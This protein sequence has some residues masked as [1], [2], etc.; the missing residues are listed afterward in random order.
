MPMGVA[1]WVLLLPGAALSLAVALRKGRLRLRECD[2]LTI[3][4]VV[5]VIGLVLALLPGLLRNTEG[6]LGLGIYDALYY[7]QADAWLQDH[8]IREAAQPDASRYD[9]TKAYGAGS[10]ELPASRCFGSRRRW[11]TFFRTSPDRTIYALLSVLLTLLPLTIWVSARA[12]GVGLVAAALGAAFGLSPALLMLVPDSALGNLAGLVLAPPALFF[13]IR[14]LSSGQRADIAPAAIL[15]GGLF[16]V[17]PE[18]VPPLLAAS[19]IGLFVH[20]VTCLRESRTRARLRTLATRLVL[21]AAATILI[22]PLPVYRAFRYLIAIGA[23]VQGQPDR[24]LTF[25]N[26]WAWA[27]GVLHLYQLPRFE[28]LSPLRTA[29][30]VALPVALALLLGLGVARSGLRRGAFVAVP[31]GTAILLGFVAYYRYQGGHCEYCL[32][33][34][35]TFLLPFVAIGLA[36]GVQRAWGIP[37]RLGLGVPLRRAAM[38]IAACGIAALIW[39]DRKLEQAS[40]YTPAVISPELRQLAKDSSL[41]IGS[42]L[43][44]EDSDTSAVSVWTTPATYYLAQGIDDVRLSFVSEGLAAAYLGIPAGT[45][46]AYYSANYQYV[47]TPFGGVKSNRTV[48][49]RR[50]P[51]ALLRR[52]LIDVTPVNLGW[53]FDPNSRVSAIPWVSKPFQLWLSNLQHERSVALTIALD[54]PFHDASTLV[55]SERG[56]PLSALMSSDGSRL[57]VDVDARK[58]LTIVDAAP[59]LATAA[60]VPPRATE[61]DPFPSPPKVLGLAE[62]QAVPGRCIGLQPRLVSQLAYGHG[63]QSAE[64]DPNGVKFRWM[65][66]VAHLVV[67][68]PA[69]PSGGT[70]AGEATVTRRRRGAATV[71]VAYGECCRSRS[72]GCYPLT[73]SATETAAL[74]AHPVITPS[75]VDNHD[76]QLLGRPL[77]PLQAFNCTKEEFPAVAVQDDDS[78]T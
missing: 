52:A 44:V 11:R 70:A 51:Y 48:L 26:G 6:P 14:W 30:A 53:S 75:V 72:R 68:G 69:Q 64:R 62:I 46:A 55:F 2:E 38:I 28:V 47:L 16:A 8:T 4:I 39:S 40:Y 77:E 54:R 61:S 49:E 67:G 10:F 21:V 13:G 3:P 58:G 27:F 34:S 50:G 31:I 24:F 15:V 1:A 23:A 59:Q 42:G 9:I 22:A 41:P 25:E 17:F 18:F 5:A 63:W 19:A 32:W 43:L 56:Q 65:G 36:L 7:I 78:N 76:L 73:I 66:S 74:R 33:K 29:V 37:R 57:C 20:W 12:L 60:T 71:G 35:L 45:G